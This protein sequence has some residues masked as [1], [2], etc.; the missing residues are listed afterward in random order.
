ERGVSITELVA[1]LNCEQITIALSASVAHADD[2][3]VANVFGDHM[4]LQQ[5]K[6]VRVWG[7][8]APVAMSL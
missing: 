8:G 5:E 6:P 3:R 2:L 4:V 7:W 1:L